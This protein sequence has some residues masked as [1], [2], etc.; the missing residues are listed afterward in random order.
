MYRKALR[1]FFIASLFVFSTLPLFE[2]QDESS[3]IANENKNQFFFGANIGET[4]GW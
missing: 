2:Y 1:V 3:I 4:G